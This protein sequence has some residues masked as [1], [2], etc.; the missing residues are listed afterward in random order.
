[1]QGLCN[2]GFGRPV[3]LPQHRQRRQLTP[4]PDLIKCAL[5]ILEDACPPEPH[6][7]LCRMCEDDDG[8][9]CRLCWQNYL[10]YVANGRELDPYRPDRIHEGGLKP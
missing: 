6:M 5:L 10:Y 7:Q 9:S 3:V 4:L 2:P 8:S 1:M